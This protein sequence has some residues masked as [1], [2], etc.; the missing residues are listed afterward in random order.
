MDDMVSRV[1][2]F[3]VKI[4]KDFPVPL[5]QKK[6]LYELSKKL[7]D[8]ATL[9]LKIEHDEIVAMVAGY[10]NDEKSRIGYISIVA[11]SEA[12][13]RNGFASSL[14]KE[15][16]EVANHKGMKLVH[17]YTSTENV[18]AIGFY[19][20]LGFVD[21]YVDNEIRPSDCHLAYYFEGEYK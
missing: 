3:L 13:R 9:C 1:H 14:V 10:T 18:N 7:C 17:L 12:V 15:F 16:L 21:Y 11:T 5:S 19:R 20:H 6:D 4:E 8:K 2:D